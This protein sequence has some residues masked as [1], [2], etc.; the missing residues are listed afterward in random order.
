MIQKKEK[1][2][3]QTNKIMTF[4]LANTVRY[5][6]KVVVAGEIGLAL[7]HDHDSIVIRK[8][9]PFIRRKKEK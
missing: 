7:Q 8:R 4:H 9:R 3:K 1:K 2:E 6:Y 5:K